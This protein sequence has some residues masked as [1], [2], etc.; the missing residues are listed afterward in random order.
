MSYFTELATVDGNTSYRTP[1]SGMI[2]NIELM[3]IPIPPESPATKGML[4]EYHPVGTVMVNSMTEVMMFES[5]DYIDQNELLL[6]THI[7]DV[8]MAKYM[9]KRHQQKVILASTLALKTHSALTAV[10]EA[11]VAPSK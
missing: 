10:V 9:E 7:K 2:K 6:K 5:D 11:G 8:S 3:G 1:T 4:E